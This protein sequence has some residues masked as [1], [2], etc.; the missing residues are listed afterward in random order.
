MFYECANC[1]RVLAAEA[2]DEES[3]SW[4]LVHFIDFVMLIL[5]EFGAQ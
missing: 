1:L 5:I 2:S 4:L 3:R